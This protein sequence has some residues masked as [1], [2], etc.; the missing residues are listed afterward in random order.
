MIP[1]DLPTRIITRAEQFRRAD[2]RRYRVRVAYT[3][4]ALMASINTEA[5]KRA[6]NAER[7]GGRG[8]AGG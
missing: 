3:A 8:R 5:G 1:A 7:A 4:Q 6:A 2:D